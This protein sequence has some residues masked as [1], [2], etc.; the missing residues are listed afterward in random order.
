MTRLPRAGEQSRRGE[1]VDRSRRAVQW[2]QPGLV[3]KRWVLTSALGFVLALL[4]AAIWADLKPIYWILTTVDDL[5]RVLAGAGREFTGPLVL[6]VGIG[7]VLLGQSRSFGSIQR[8]LAPQKDT[9]L[10]DALLAQRRLNR[11][12]NI[13]PSE[14]APDFPPCSAASSATVQSHRHRHGGR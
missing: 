13:G 12:P 10:V 2:L 5:L 7:L 4:G 1:L 8:A 3:V 11:G 14:V 6:L 9:A